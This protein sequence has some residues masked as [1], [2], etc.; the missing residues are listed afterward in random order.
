VAGA[1][2]S[3]EDSI[4]RLTFGVAAVSLATLGLAACALSS[5]SSQT[6]QSRPDGLS[7]R[8]GYLVPWDPR[9]IAAVDQG[10]GDRGALSELS[11]VWYQPD[12]M[13]KI[14][15]A[16]PEAQHSAS[17][18]E[19]QAISRGLALMPSIA[20]YRQGGWDSALVH[21]LLT[22]PQARAAHISAVLTLV[23]SHS[24]AGI[25]LDYES[26]PSADREAYSAFIRD[27]SGALHKEHKRLSLTVHAKT[28]EPG[29]WSGAQAE[30]WRALGVSADE[31]RIMAYDHAT[32]Q[33]APGPIAPLSW[34]ERVLRLAVSEIPRDKVL[35]G[36]GTYGYDWTGA[37]EGTSVQWADAE[38]TARDHAV[39]VEWDAS[40]SAPWFTF[41]DTSGR[42]HTVWYENARS[43]QA[44]VDLA[45]QYRIAGVFVWR[46]G[47]EDPAIWDALR[48]AG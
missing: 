6:S 12:E 28:S 5:S 42:L 25:D 36:V 22:D 20:N 4:H 2:E 19:K 41:T 30:D 7:I 14:V 46:L 1:E 35:L 33:T 3:R 24:W 40:S 13:G 10:A 26:L 21:R 31:I 34:V 43:L 32:D 48:H 15:F 45:R 16:S 39:A 11:P 29:D 27:L 44:K 18:M 9:G 17:V 37:N 23:Q 38:A 8:V 47:G